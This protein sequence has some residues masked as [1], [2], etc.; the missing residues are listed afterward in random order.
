MTS[1]HKFEH[2]IVIGGSMAGLLAARSL[3]DHFSRVTLIERDKFSDA[4]ESRRGQ[5]QTRHLHGLL[6][7]GRT[8]LETYFP[9]LTASLQVSLNRKPAIYPAI[10]LEKL[11]ITVAR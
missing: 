7:G 10:L 6:A 8:I 3:S 2:A 4:P 11:H 1:A 9:G 5:P